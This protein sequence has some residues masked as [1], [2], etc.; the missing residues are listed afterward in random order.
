M[1]RG[2]QHAAWRRDG[3]QGGPGHQ[4]PKNISPL[5]SE[6]NAALGLDKTSFREVT[7]RTKNK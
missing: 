4:E 2:T 5:D 6:R 1:R 7:K 3:A